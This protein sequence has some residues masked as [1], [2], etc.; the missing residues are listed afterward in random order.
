MISN[1]PYINKKNKIVILKTSNMYF[2][3]SSIFQ[4]IFSNSSDYNYSCLPSL[5]S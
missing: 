2:I 4:Y 5:K 3:G 1:A